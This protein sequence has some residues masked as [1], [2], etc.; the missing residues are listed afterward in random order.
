MSVN[1][2]AKQVA[3]HGA[4]FCRKKLFFFSIPFNIRKAVEKTNATF[5]MHF[6]HYKTCVNKY[7]KREKVQ[8]HY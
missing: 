2:L 6:L 3:I 5:I 7:E 4:F 1:M 8:Q